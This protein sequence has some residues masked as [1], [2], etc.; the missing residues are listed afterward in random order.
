VA[1]KSKKTGEFGEN[2]VEELLKMIGWIDLIKNED[3]PC[4]SEKYHQ[5]SNKPRK[6]HGIDF[7]FNYESQLVNNRQESNVI[8]VKYEESYSSFISDFKSYLKDIALAIQCFPYSNFY[9]TNV[10]PNI[11]NKHI[12]GVIF[13]LSRTDNEFNKDI[14]KEIT[15]FRNSDNIRFESI[16][17]VDNL[18]ASFLYS[19]IKDL[20]SRYPND[21]HFLYQTTGNN[22]NT[23]NRKTDGIILPVEMITSPIHII[24]SCIGKQETLNIYLLKPY[25]ENDFGRL[26]SLSRD[27]TEN[28]ASRIQIFFEKYDKLQSENSVNNIKSK[29]ADKNLTQKIDV[30]SFVLQSFKKL[31]ENR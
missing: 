7:I 9:K 8:S 23:I 3:I 30:S 19:V 16:Y 27:L 31:E 2:V 11:E 15:S 20:N 5:I 13:W 29:F 14:Y 24:K 1:E 18:R 21:Y 25:N 22:I 12:N 6:T 17:L 4:F 10:A 26:I 28:W